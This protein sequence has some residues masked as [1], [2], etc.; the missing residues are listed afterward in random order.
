MKLKASIRYQ[1]SETKKAVIFYYAI[2]VLSLII[3]VVILTI[4]RSAFPNIFRVGEFNF[5]TFNT[6]TPIFLFV[7]GLCSFKDNFLMFIQNGTSRRSLF[8]G[9]IATSTALAVGLTAADYLFSLIARGFTGIAGFP[10][11]SIGLTDAFPKNI[12]NSIA[13]PFLVFAVYFLVQFLGYLIT[14]LLY[15][16]NRGGQI[17]VGVSVPVFLFIIFPIIDELVF[18]GAV[19]NAIS[20]FMHI[21]YGL[22]SGIAWLGVISSLVC[23][24]ILGFFC[25]LLIRRVRV[26]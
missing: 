12:S 18:N 26:K 8:L 6:V 1:L 20:R 4:V 25:W 3:G 19:S 9:R 14:S 2:L 11:V 21:V 10:S 23:A 7:L 5:G 16:L 24:A 17:A 22:Q 15:R 13:G